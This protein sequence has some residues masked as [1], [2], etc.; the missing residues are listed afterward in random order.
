M[1]DLRSRL[2]RDSGSSRIRELLH[3]TE[4]PDMLSLAGG[5]PA[6]EALP[7]ERIRSALATTLDARALQYGPTEGVHDLREFVAGR[8]GVTVDEVL[9]TNGAQQALDLIARAVINPG[10][11]AVV[12]SP[13]Y[14]GATQVLSNTGASITASP[15]TTTASIPDCCTTWSTAD[16][17]PSSST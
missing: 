7:V 4:R 17:G 2:A 12:E 16:C 3:L 15:A 9:I 14:L 13:S 6:T 1:E 8:H 10:D 11:R 5:L